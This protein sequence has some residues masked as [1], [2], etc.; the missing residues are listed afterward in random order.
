MNENFQFHEV[1]TYS[2]QKDRLIFIVIGVG[3]WLLNI[4]SKTLSINSQSD[5][6]DCWVYLKLC[7]STHHNYIYTS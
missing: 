1:H 7:M 3:K 5:W 2:T 6:N 4:S